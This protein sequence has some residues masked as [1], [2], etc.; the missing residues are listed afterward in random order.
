MMNLILKYLTYIHVNEKKK[1]NAEV[2]R[3]YEV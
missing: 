2:R 1:N 3:K